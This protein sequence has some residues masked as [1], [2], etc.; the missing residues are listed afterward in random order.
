MSGPEDRRLRRIIRPHLLLAEGPDDEAVTRR[1]LSDAGLADVQVH[2]YGGRSNLSDA[3]NTLPVATGF[4]DLEVLAVTRDADESAEA[5][6]RSITA[7]LEKPRLPVPDS[8]GSSARTEKLTVWVT[9]IPPGRESGEIE[10]LVVDSLPN[11]VR[12]CLDTYFTCQGTALGLKPKK[13][14]KSR[15]QC[16]LAALGGELRRGMRDEVD[17]ID[18]AHPA[19]DPLREFLRRAFTPPAGAPTPP[20]TA[21]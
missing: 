9:T 11:E 6:F 19:F 2:N 21:P 20:A 10:D 4:G 13:P 1:L 15:L 17:R 16:W 18:V 8:N 12:N 3:L 14:G 7:A 5:T